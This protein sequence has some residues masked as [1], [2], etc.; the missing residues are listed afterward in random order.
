MA[1]WDPRSTPTWWSTCGSTDCAARRL[2]HPPR[3]ARGDAKPRAEYP[4]ACEACFAARASSMDST[5]RT[6][7][8]FEPWHNPMGTDGFEFV[9]YAAPD[10][11]AL[12]ALFARLGFRAIARHRHKRVTLYR[13]GAINF[14]VNAEPDSF[15]Q[16]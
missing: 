10:P 4:W 13:Q 3:P 15:G 6:T 5:T 7:M 11:D 16:R 2:A 8:S 1:R 9:E 12:G 14:I